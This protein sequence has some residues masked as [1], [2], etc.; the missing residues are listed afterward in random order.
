MSAKT[1]AWTSHFLAAVCGGALVAAVAYVGVRGGADVAT[2]DPAQSV[3]EPRVT[4]LAGNNSATRYTWNLDYSGHTWCTAI[5]GR[6]GVS[7]FCRTRA[8]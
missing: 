8:D 2:R 5:V 4:E 7:T 1:S 6:G 3:V